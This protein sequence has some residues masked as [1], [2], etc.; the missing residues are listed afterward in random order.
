MDSLLVELTNDYASILHLVAQGWCPIECSIDGGRDGPRSIVDEL[1]MDHHLERSNLDPPSLRAYQM[2][3][4]ARRDDPRFVVTGRADADAC[5]AIAALAGLL[6]HPTTEPPPGFNGISWFSRCDQTDHLSQVIAE[7]D[8]GRSYEARKQFPNAANLLATWNGLMTFGNNQYT[9]A[10]LRLGVGLWQA[11]TMGLISESMAYA[12]S[13]IRNGIASIARSELGRAM[14]HQVNQ[15][16]NDGVL[17][18]ES[19]G[20]NDDFLMW[21]QHFP[22][23][24]DAPKTTAAAW[25][26]PVVVVYDQVAK[27]CTV[28][29]P[30][31][32]VAAELFGVGGLL[33]VYEHLPPSRWGGRQDKGG[34]PRGVKLSVE[35]AI[36]ATEYLRARLVASQISLNE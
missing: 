11:L 12:G 26:H 30:N 3:F 20:A 1:E 21:H 34:S 7:A 6:P 14:E 31:P 28:S 23:S 22:S 27:C 35:T 15:P 10:G 24:S 18:I 29:C 32:D 17:L 9:T 33:N 25:I 16:T 8:L 36:Q 19:Q 5:F 13:G 2:H 4:G